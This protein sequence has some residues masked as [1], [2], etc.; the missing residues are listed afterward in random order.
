VIITK[1]EKVVEVVVVVEEEERFTDLNFIV[2]YTYMYKQT[3]VH[4]QV[5][6]KS[7]SRPNKL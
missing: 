3:I 4:K 2:S 6:R 1:H 5:E 7:T